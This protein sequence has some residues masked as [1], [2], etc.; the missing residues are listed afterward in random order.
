MC[1]CNYQDVIKGKDIVLFVG[2][3]G[4]GKTTMLQYL[5]GA[6]MT[7][8]VT[9]GIPHLSSILPNTGSCLGGLEKFAASHLPKSETKSIMALQLRQ[10][11]DMIS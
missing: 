8:S 7:E 5:F 9:D 3:T 4:T 10:I 6:K 2:Y 1:L 11:Y